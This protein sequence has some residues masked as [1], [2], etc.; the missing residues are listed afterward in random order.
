MASRMY[1]RGWDF[2]APPQTVVYHLWSRAHRPSFRQV[3][4]GWDFPWVRVKLE[5]DTLIPLCRKA[6]MNIVVLYFVRKVGHGMAHSS[7]A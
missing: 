6:N 1:T 3:R 2:F 7:V 4:K 5:R